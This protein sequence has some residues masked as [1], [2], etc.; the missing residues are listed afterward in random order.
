[1]GLVSLAGCVGHPEPYH[2]GYEERPPEVKLE[3]AEA[4][5]RRLAV[6]LEIVRNSA[7][8]EAGRKEIGR[9]LGEVPRNVFRSYE[10]SIDATLPASMAART[11]RRPRYYLERL[12]KKPAASGEEEAEGGEGAEEEEGAEGEE[13]WGDEED[14]DYEE[15]WDE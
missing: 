10:D 9:I 3:D 14:E 4:R 8:Y 6:P 15:D 13:D 1:M 12:N 7:Y 2:P 11:L 5:A